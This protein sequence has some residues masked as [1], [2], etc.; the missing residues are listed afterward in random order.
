MEAPGALEP[1]AGVASR[2]G[3]L[4]VRGPGRLGG[5]AGACVHTVGLDKTGPIR[6][7]LHRMGQAPDLGPTRRDLSWNGWSR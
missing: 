2:L 6:V 7:R 1:A 5:I 4:H 3:P